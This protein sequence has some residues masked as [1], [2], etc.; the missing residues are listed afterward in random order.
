M[1]GGASS[2]MQKDV[3][4]DKSM[5]PFGGYTSLIE[6]QHSKLSPYFE[7]IYLSSKTKKTDGSYKYILDATDIDG[8]PTDALFGPTLS[9]FSALSVLQCDTLFVPVDMPLLTPET[10]EAI[11][12]SKKNETDA[13]VLKSGDKIY[14]TCAL[15]S[16]SVLPKLGQMILENRHKLQLFLGEIDTIYLE[17]PHSDEFANIN[18]YSDYLSLRAQ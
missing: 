2:R 16:P 4:K 13:V 6:Y 8:S 18:N 5:L 9:L 1:C 15:Y 17:L 12:M 11:I 7:N 3:G 14:P 10:I